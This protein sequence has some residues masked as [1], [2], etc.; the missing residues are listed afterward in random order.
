VIQIEREIERE[1][2][3]CRHRVVEIL[4]EKEIECESD[5]EVQ[6]K[7]LNVIN[8]SQTEGDNIK[9]M[10]TITCDLYI[11]IFCKLDV[12]IQSHYVTDNINR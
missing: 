9:R 1:I 7:P 11:A 6:Y 5:K 4:R 10:I 3:I 12:E 8:L 2:S